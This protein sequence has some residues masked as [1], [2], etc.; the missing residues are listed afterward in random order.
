MNNEIIDPITPEDLNP[1]PFAPLAGNTS[2]DDA[3][4]YEEDFEAADQG[5][6]KYT[7][8]PHPKETLPLANRLVA[9]TLTISTGGG[10]D[11]VM[12]LPEDVRRKRL[13]VHIVGAS[14]GLTPVFFGSS[15]T[16]VYNGALVHAVRY[17]GNDF[18]NPPVLDLEGYTG[19]FW[20]RLNAALAAGTIFITATGISG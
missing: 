16:D 10:V 5:P 19:A 18:V 8:L 9:S 11:P 14:A 2:D 6:L 17:A 7:G 4:A 12:V 3:L 20:V 1:V 13:I 15:K